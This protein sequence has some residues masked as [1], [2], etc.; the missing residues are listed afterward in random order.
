MDHTFLGT[1][2]DDHIARRQEPH[3]VNQQTPWDD[4]R[5]FVGDLRLERRTQRELHI[6]GSEMETARLRA[7]QHPG[8]DLDARACR[9]GSCDDSQLLREV[10]ARARDLYPRFRPYS[11]VAFN[12]LRNLV[13][14]IGAVGP[15]TS[16]ETPLS[17]PFLQGRQTGDKRALSTGRAFTGLVSH[18][19]SVPAQG[20]RQTCPHESAARSWTSRG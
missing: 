11:G 9:D 12:H 3:E 15:G 16:P 19:R 7:K 18:V 13:V 17:K 2:L 6:S 1:L 10:V 14:V 4:C 5:S 20:C 8:E